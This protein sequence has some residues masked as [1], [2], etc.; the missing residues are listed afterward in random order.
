LLFSLLLLLLQLLLNNVP[1]RQFNDLAAAAS[2]KG[3]RI[4]VSQMLRF[5]ISE[6]VDGA[7]ALCCAAASPV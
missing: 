4:E 1:R 6:L 5:P 2:A 3:K 7:C